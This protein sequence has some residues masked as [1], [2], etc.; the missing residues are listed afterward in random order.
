M[1]LENFIL[2]GQQVLVLFILIAVGFA[3]GKLGVIT[4]HAS[5]KMT[6]IVLYVVT[7]CV[8]LNAFQR[9][10]S[11][12]LL[13]QIF[14]AAGIAAAIFIASILLVRLTVHDK[15]IAR[16]KVLQFSVIF[17]NCGLAT[18]ACFS[19]PFLLHCSMFFAGRTVWLI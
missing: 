19:V 13:G 15:D 8:M 16:R 11:F 17:S 10:F 2:I 14:L 7:P 12:D 3:C 18:T 6:D 1:F 4:E 9:D 5:K